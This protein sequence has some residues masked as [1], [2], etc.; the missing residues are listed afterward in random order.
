MRQDTSD[1][2]LNLGINEYIYL[3]EID[4]NTAKIFKS[5]K[6]YCKVRYNKDITE[7]DIETLYKHI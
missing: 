7:S 5:I 6:E 3:K 1:Y 4:E 2:L